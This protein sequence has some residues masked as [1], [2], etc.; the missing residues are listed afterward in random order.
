MK[1]TVKRLQA[2]LGDKREALAE[3]RV[4]IEKTERELAWALCPFA[5]GETITWGRGKSRRQRGRVVDCVLFLDDGV[6][7]YVRPEGQECL[8]TVLGAWDRPRRARV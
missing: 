5:R 8:V 1:A 3:L 6:Q 7:L 2:D 4:Q